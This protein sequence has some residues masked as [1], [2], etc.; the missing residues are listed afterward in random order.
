MFSG[1]PIMNTITLKGWAVCLGG[2]D[3][4]CFSIDNGKTWST[5]EGTFE[6]GDPSMGLADQ[7]TWWMDTSITTSDAKK[8]LFNANS[9]AIKINLS[10]V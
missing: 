4:Y 2:I 8:S 7:A 3:S 10:Q 6:N 9:T 5:I 1:M